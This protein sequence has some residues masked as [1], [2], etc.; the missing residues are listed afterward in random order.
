[1]AEVQPN[2]QILFTPE[3]GFSGSVSFT[4]IVADSQ[5]LESNEATVTVQV[6]NSKWQNPAVSL[7]VSADGR[8][9]AIDALLIINYLNSGQPRFLPDS[10]YVA[11][12]FI[13]VNG[14]ERVSALDALLVI[15]HLNS[16]SSGGG[17]EGEGEGEAYDSS[18]ASDFAMMVTPQQMIDTVGRQVVA[19]L[20]EQWIESLRNTESLKST[21]NAPTA[22]TAEYR[23]PGGRWSTG[24]TADAADTPRE[25]S[26]E[27]VLSL[28]S[29]RSKGLRA[30]Q[31]MVDQCFADE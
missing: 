17:S 28:L 26:E 30:K 24:G 2:G 14:D 1:L 3:T 6:R 13:D 25:M 22:S 5:G 11:P 9:S 31:D 27:E 19:R 20:Q 8:I 10:D 15:N 21:A 7:D 23:L 4:Y 16:R 18:S 12:L 29:S